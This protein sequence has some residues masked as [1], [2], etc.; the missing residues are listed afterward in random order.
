MRQ[1]RRVIMMGLV[2]G[3][4][5]HARAGDGPAHE[6]A[7]ALAAATLQPRYPDGVGR[8]IAKP[9]FT[10][11]H[12]KTQYYNVTPFAQSF[13][14]FGP[15]SPVGTWVNA[16][17]GWPCTGSVGAFN[18]VPDRLGAALVK[19]FPEGDQ[20][21]TLASSGLDTFIAG[22]R[23]SLKIAFFDKSFNLSDMTGI[24][25]MLC[26]WTHFKDNPAPRRLE[27]TKTSA[28]LTLGGARE[29]L[30]AIERKT[31]STS[32]V[33]DLACSYRKRGAKVSDCYSRYDYIVTEGGSEGAFCDQKT[34]ET[35]NRRVWN[36]AHYVQDAEASFHA[37]GNSKCSPTMSWL[38]YQKCVT[39]LQAALDET[40]DKGSLFYTEI[41]AS[42]SGPQPPARKLVCDAALAT[43]KDFEGK[44][45]PDGNGS[46]TTAELTGTADALL[47]VC[48]G[49]YSMGSG[50]AG[51][52][53][54]LAPV[55]AVCAGLERTISH[56]CGRGDDF[57][58]GP[59]LP[60]ENRNY[61][62]GEIFVTKGRD[63]IQ[64]AKAATTAFVEQ[65]YLEWAAVCK[66]P[67]VPCDETQCQNWCERSTRLDPRR[68]TVVGVCTHPV[69]TNQC[70][71]TF[72][73]CDCLTGVTKPTGGYAWSNESIAECAG[74]QGTTGLP[75]ALF[76][77]DFNPAD[78]GTEPPLAGER[79]FPGTKACTKCGLPG[80]PCCPGYGCLA[81]VTVSDPLRPGQ[82]IQADY[83]C[84]NKTTKQA[85]SADKAC[86]SWL[87]NDCECVPRTQ[88]SPGDCG[89]VADGCGGVLT[90]SCDGGV[91]DAAVPMPDA[92]TANDGGM[93][94][95][96]APDDASI[97]D[98]APSCGG[99]NQACCTAGQACLPGGSCN[100]GSGFCE[101]C[102]DLNQ[103]CCG[104]TS[105]NSGGTPLACHFGSCVGCGSSGSPCCPTGQ[106]CFGTLAC[107][108]V[109]QQCLPTT[110][111]GEHQACCSGDVCTQAFTYCSG[112][113]CNHCGRG[114]D[115]CC[116]P[117]DSC[118][119]GYVCR[120]YSATQNLCQLPIP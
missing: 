87:A 73:H 112:G 11:P 66:L 105:C 26:N 51:L 100:A 3:L 50:L 63:F 21:Y 80:L 6:R 62:E 2:V 75:G 83:A 97:V 109:S 98:A 69:A 28:T 79:C 110:C 25:A 54:E 20:G 41:V 88:C 114:G 34:W 8:P 117:D 49:K 64:P 84:V 38:D 27:D 32:S 59:G 42:T 82:T 106:P 36:A 56:H 30:R 101:P 76:H 57:C 33:D 60:T 19:Q 65:A 89:Q 92:A 72:D 5:A 4:T 10:V 93:P 47:A 52:D 35:Y 48:R 40:I 115:S 16:P 107:N 43:Y 9:G 113:Q 104:G 78:L 14:V 99:I 120:P 15:S 58:L 108:A 102:G 7:A 90:C 31:T 53:V 71:G 23:G 1:A 67:D 85:A 68:E 103:A 116:P 118:A 18:A 86:P 46:Y 119:P 39:S 81:K 95:A 91:P 61:C 111:G 45:F 29:L 96:A 44:T 13:P 94:D 37:L 24:T 74:E 12:R 22:I 77:C 17:D 70:P 55:N